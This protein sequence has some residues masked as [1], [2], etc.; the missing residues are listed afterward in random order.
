MKFSDAPAKYIKA[1]DALVSTSTLYEA[2]KALKISGRTLDRY[3]ADPEFQEAY[4]DALF[5]MHQQL[6]GQLQKAAI[7]GFKALKDVAENG[8]V[9]SARVSAGRTLMEFASKGIESIHTNA[10]LEA[11]EQQ[12]AELANGSSIGKVKG[13]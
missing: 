12:L 4:R 1:I 11:L 2:A 10:R 5:Q 3:L 8:Q 9:E 13:T 6:I 7:D